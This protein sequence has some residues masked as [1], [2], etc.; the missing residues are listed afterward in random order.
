VTTCQ[1]MERI[2]KQ[3]NKG[4]GGIRERVYKECVTVT[5]DKGNKGQGK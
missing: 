2:S 1:S 4:K 5:C 3:Y